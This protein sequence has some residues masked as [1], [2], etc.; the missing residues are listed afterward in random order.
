MVNM[1]SI[2]VTAIDSSMAVSTQNA[3]PLLHEIS[4][5]LNALRKTGE[6]TTIDLSALPLN[7]ADKEQLFSTLG[8]GEVDATVTALGDTK[9]QETRYAG[10]WLVQYF[11]PQGNELATHIEI[12][13]TPNMLLTPP[14]DIQDAA[15]AL[16]DQISLTMQ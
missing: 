4:H 8:K 7:S 2:P 14:E 11:S 10:V 9:I 1:Q 13:P 12:T 16:A 15:A 3:L 6:K 5:A